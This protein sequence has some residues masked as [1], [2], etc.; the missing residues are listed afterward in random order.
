MAFLLIFWMALWLP[1]WTGL[2]TCHSLCFASIVD[3]F[4][5]PLLPSSYPSPSHYTRTYKLVSCLRSNYIVSLSCAGMNRIYTS[6]SLGTDCSNTQMP[7][8]YAYQ[9]RQRLNGVPLSSVLSYHA[10]EDHQPCTED[11][12]PRIPRV[13]SRG[14][15]VIEARILMTGRGS[16]NTKVVQS[17]SVPAILEAPGEADSK[18]SA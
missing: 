6:L 11:A 12:R 5:R 1:G 16:Q 13:R 9:G 3:T 8:R 17:P 4:A 14:I 2:M 7:T 18:A 10:H 15:V